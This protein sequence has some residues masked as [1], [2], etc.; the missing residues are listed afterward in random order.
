MKMSIS[1]VI[2]LWFGAALFCVAE[3]AAAQA[4]TVFELSGT[5][6]ATPAGGT[7]RILRKGDSVNQGETVSTGAA[8]S[9]VLRF[10]DGQV[11]ALA[12][13]SRLVVTTYVYDRTDAGKSNVLISL[14]QGGMRAV[15]GLIGKARP[16][17]VAY[18][19][20]G[21]TIGIRGTDTNI[22]VDGNVVAVS[23][24][25]GQVS[26]SFGGQT[27]VLSAGQ[28]V[29]TTPSGAIQR[30]PASGVPAALRAQG[31]PAAAVLAA[32]MTSLDNPAIA[33]AVTAASQAPSGTP[34]S[35][36]TVGSGTGTT[37][38]TGGSGGAGGGTASP[39]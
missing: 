27:V 35:T 6:Q 1:K 24:T 29:I 38:T 25:D 26:F 18:R 33:A 17:Q 13:N 10:E 8:S 12:A 39:K 15:T 2:S 21:A 31:S 5:A 19:A 20:A 22:T 16:Q 7:A 23:V 37:T 34:P 11:A 30:V 3:L 4:A 9:A 14:L 32:A 36:G 28:G